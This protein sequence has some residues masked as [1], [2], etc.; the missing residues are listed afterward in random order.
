MGVSHNVRAGC[1]EKSCY[2]YYVI[3][4]IFKMNYFVFLWG[5]LDLFKRRHCMFPIVVIVVFQSFHI[6]FHIILST[7]LR[8]NLHKKI[9][10]SFEWG[11]DGLLFFFSFCVG[12]HKTCQHLQHCLD[13]IFYCACA[14]HSPVLYRG[15]NILVANKYRCARIFARQ[16]K[17]IFPSDYNPVTERHVKS[18]V[19]RGG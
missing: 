15:I 11:W 13:L 19:N 8:V 18:Y 9:L 14:S 5:N 6:P 4:V 16:G 12:V 1:L 2:S 3:F 10:I 17:Q 7:S